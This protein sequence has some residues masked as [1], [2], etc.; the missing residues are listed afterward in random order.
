VATHLPQELI[1]MG[2]AAL[3]PAGG[4]RP[5][6]WIEA[7]FNETS[8]RTIREY[9]WV[10]YKYRWLGGVCFVTVLGIALLITLMADRG[11]IPPRRASWS[12]G[13]PP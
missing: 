1:S 11:S 7:E 8:R 13:K 10:L 4:A 9:L 5:G 2:P 3:A 6:E 12:R